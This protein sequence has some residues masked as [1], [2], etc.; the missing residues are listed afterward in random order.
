VAA[1]SIDQITLHIAKTT[2]AMKKGLDERTSRTAFADRARTKL[3]LTPANVSHVN[4]LKIA[5]RSATSIMF[6]GP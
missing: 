6:T 4:L 5:L 2:S 3:A 1:G